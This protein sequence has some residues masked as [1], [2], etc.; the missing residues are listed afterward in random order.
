VIAA[1]CLGFVTATASSSPVVRDTTPRWVGTAINRLAKLAVKPA[2]PM[3]GYSRAKF[4]P[5]W[6]DV[7]RNHCNT[8]DDILKRDLRPFTLKPGSKCIVLS[9]DLHDPYTGKV[10]HFVRGAASTVVQIDHVVALAAAWRTGAADWRPHRR[11]FYANDP[12]V[13]LAVD[14]PANE[15]K[16]DGDASEWVAPQYTCRYVAQQI[17][18]KKKYTLWVT[19]AEHDRVAQ[20]LAG[21]SAP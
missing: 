4:G 17:A 12:D 11:L 1:C 6:Q 7:D 9:G 5:A 13:L 18:I 15:Q 19:A 21:C 14:G 20:Y 2:A 3:T 8:R 16:S 10:I